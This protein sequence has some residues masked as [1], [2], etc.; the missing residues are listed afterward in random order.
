MKDFGVRNL[1][2]LASRPSIYGFEM[3]QPIGCVLGSPGDLVAI[4][5][6]RT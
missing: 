3:V 6:N 2:D 4:F 1:G 5:R